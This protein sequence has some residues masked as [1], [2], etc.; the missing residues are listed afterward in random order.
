MTVDGSD[1]MVRSDACCRSWHGPRRAQI[2]SCMEA[3]L[4]R[5]LVIY[6]QP[7]DP[8]TFERYY[9]ETHVPLVQQLP[10]LQAFWVSQGSVSASGDSPCHLVAEIAF[11]SMDDLESALSSAEGV[12]VRE[13]VT[14]FAE[15]LA[16]VLTFDER[17]L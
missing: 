13:D 3:S 10:G 17:R 4:A 1:N 15:G 12:A 5:L 11:D 9:Y 6:G 8:V 7:S 14:N 16:T 2:M